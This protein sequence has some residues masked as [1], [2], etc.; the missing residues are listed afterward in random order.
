VRGLDLAPNAL[1][2]F[3]DALLLALYALQFID[4][5]PEAFKPLREFGA[6]GFLFHPRAPLQSGVQTRYGGRDLRGRPSSMQ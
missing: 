5:P 6:V 4:Q 1:G 2:D 3:I